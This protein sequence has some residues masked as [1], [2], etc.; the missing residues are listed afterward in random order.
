MFCTQLNSIKIPKYIS[1]KQHK[2]EEE[3]LKQC[4]K[5]AIDLHT[6]QLDK[7]KDLNNE[8][9]EL[10]DCKFIINNPHLFKYTFFIDNALKKF[11][12]SCLINETSFSSSVEMKVIKLNEGSLI[13]FILK[14]LPHLK[15][16][17]VLCC[18]FNDLKKDYDTLKLC[19]QNQFDDL[20]ICIDTE[21]DDFD[22]LLNHLTSLFK[23][24]ES[25]KI[26]VFSL[27]FYET[28]DVYYLKR[29]SNYEKFLEAIN[30]FILSSVMLNKFKFES[31]DLDLNQAVERFLNNNQ[32]FLSNKNIKS[33]K[34]EQAIINS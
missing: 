7:I 18:D 19:K 12:V 2:E 33:N 14:N 3:N 29:P 4:L 24:L 5:T 31:N 8:L 1:M 21:I 10:T 23:L 28:I 20:L 27:V 32:R 34:L 25:Y 9:K 17:L 11:E 30:H 16:N 6:L 13:F 26:N 15:L 22:K